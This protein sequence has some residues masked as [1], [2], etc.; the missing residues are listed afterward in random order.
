M[1]AGVFAS[2]GEDKLIAVWDL[3]RQDAAIRGGGGAAAGDESGPDAKK[4][5]TG[6]SALPPQLMFHHAGHRSEVVAYA[7]WQREH[8]WQASAIERDCC[9]LLFKA[10]C[11]LQSLLSLTGLDLSLLMMSGCHRGIHNLTFYV[12]GHRGFVCRLISSQDGMLLACAIV[13]S[14][15][16]EDTACTPKWTVPVIA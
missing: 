14:K 5:R 15:V 12:S 4:A 6:A 1:A 2:G 3:E 11:Q 10:A 7:T 9:Q 13:R 8:L 16:A